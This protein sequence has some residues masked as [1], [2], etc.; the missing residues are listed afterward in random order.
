MS[1]PRFLAAFSFGTRV[2]KTLLPL[3]RPQIPLSPSPHFLLATV[4]LSRRVDFGKDLEPLLHWVPDLGVGHKTGR[5]TRACRVRQRSS[6]ATLSLYTFFTSLLNTRSI[7]QAS[8]P[9]S[10]QTSQNMSYYDNQQWP[11][12]SKPSWEQQT[13]PARS[14]M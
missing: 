11:A 8:V 2:S 10:S 3:N 5:L 9:R 7:L 13:P 14:G 6:F 1:H 12:T 4:Y